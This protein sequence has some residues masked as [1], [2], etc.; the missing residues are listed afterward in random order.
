MEVYV[1]IIVDDNNRVIGTSGTLND[2]TKRKV[3]EMELGDSENR[4]RTLVELY[5]EGLFVHN[6]KCVSFVNDQALVLL[7]VKN[8]EDIIG[9]AFTRFLV[10]YERERILSLLDSLLRKQ[11]STPFE[12]ELTFIR[13]DGTEIIVEVGIS[14]ITYEG[15]L[16]V[17]CVFRDITA[18]KNEQLELLRITNAV[19]NASD[20]I[21]I[22]YQCTGKVIFMNKSFRKMFGYSLK[23]INEIGGGRGLYANPAIGRE[24]F[25]SLL[26]R[27]G[28]HGEVEMVNKDGQKMWVSVRGN[29]VEDHRGNI[30]SLL[31]VHTDISERKAMEEELRAARDAALEASKAKSEFLATMSHEIRTPLN[32]IIGIADLL[33]ESDLSEEQEQYVRVY[34]RAGENLLSIIN[35]ILDISKIESGEIRLS[36]QV[37]DLRNLIE[38]KIKLFSV[39]AK[40]KTINLEYNMSQDVPP[41]VYG[42]PDR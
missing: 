13:E 23:E 11:I 38:Q 32:A 7:G 25:Q 6:R 31:G 40:K 3:T 14:V 19:E 27:Q 24:V 10:R 30:I 20:A 37:F 29:F 41:I 15:E 28:W 42:D 22:T 8:K 26:E 35:A 17:L 9:R 16:S 34:K 36:N 4:Y 2:I 18:R 21:G 39:L 1:Q 5:P 12:Q 33:S